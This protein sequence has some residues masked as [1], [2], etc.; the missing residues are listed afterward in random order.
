LLTAELVLL[1]M[2]QYEKYHKKEIV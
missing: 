1:V 2:E